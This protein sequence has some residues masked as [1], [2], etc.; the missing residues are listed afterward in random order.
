[1]GS[2]TCSSSLLAAAHRQRLYEAH[3]ISFAGQTAVWAS[4]TGGGQTAVW[5][6]ISAKASL[7][8]GAQMAVRAGICLAEGQMAV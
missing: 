3:C 4:T 6:R 7:T 1:M 5:A 2:M 8:A